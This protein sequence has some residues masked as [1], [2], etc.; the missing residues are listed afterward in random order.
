MSQSKSMWEKWKTLN[1]SNN[2]R[3]L[4][5]SLFTYKFMIPCAT[6]NND[7]HIV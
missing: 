5:F 3:K 4:L 2:K 1:L 6:R 7:N